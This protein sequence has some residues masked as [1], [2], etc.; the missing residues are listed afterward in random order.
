MRTLLAD[1]R[2]WRVLDA[3]WL[4]ALMIFIIAGMPLASFHGDEAMLIYMSHDYAKAFIYGDP[5]GLMVGPPYYVD[6]DPWLR[7]LNGS[8]S[9]HTIGLSWH[10]AGLTNGDLPPVPGWDW[11]LDYQ[12]NVDTGHRPSEAML[13]AG[14]LPSTIFLALSAVMMFVL[15]KQLGGRPLAYFASAFYGLHPAILLNGRRAVME[16]SLLYFGLAAV[17]VA[18]IISRKREA[19]V[20]GLWGWWLVLTLAAALALASKH[21]AIVFV[22]AAYGWIFLSE[23]VRR[24]GG[25]LLRTTLKLAISSVLAGALFIALSPALWNDPAARLQDLVT[26]RAGLL[27]TQVN[28]DPLAPMPLAERIRQAIAQPFIEPV[29][30]YEVAGWGGYEPV[31]QEI[32]R[33]MASPLSGLQFGVG[34]LVLTLLAGWGIICLF[35]PRLRPG[36]VTWGQAAGLLLWLLLNLAFA[37]INPLPWQRYYLPLIPVYTLLAGVGLLAL[38]SLVRNAS[39]EGLRPPRMA[40]GR[41]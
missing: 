23:A 25:I 12:T 3:V 30:H 18:V 28:S 38:V 41:I 6:T 24:R 36:C 35:S 8:V 33:Y 4:L 17:L 27:D 7:L 15:G 14:R 22:A 9:R 2:F 26:V 16:G 39:R 13:L 19:G 10:L 37:L 31:T 20:R 21:S 29:A 11:G 32:A 1:K 5:M 40:D 34:G